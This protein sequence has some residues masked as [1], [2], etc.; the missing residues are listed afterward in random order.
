MLKV[1]EYSRI[2]ELR[3]IPKSKNWLYK[4]QRKGS[5]SKKDGK[6]TARATL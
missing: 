2:K 4:M 5:K 1:K 6:K 3:K